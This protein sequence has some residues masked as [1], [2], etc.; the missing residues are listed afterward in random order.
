MSASCSGRPESSASAAASRNA[1]PALLS[2]ATE[3]IW[4]G[5]GGMRFLSESRPPVRPA[6]AM[7]TSPRT[8]PSWKPLRAFCAWR[9][10]RST[11][12][13][14]RLLF[15]GLGQILLRERKAGA[16]ELEDGLAELDARSPCLVDARAGE[17]VGGTGALADARESV[18][19]EE[20]LAVLAGFFERFCAPGAQY[21]ALEMTP[22]RGMLD[23][24]LQI[25]IGRCARDRPARRERRC[26]RRRD[27]PDARR[28]SRRSQAREIRRCARPCRARAWCL[29]AAR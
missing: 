5:A 29:Q 18:A 26:R 1:R 19:G 13:A 22:E 21:A 9:A 3:R 23:V 6:S 11:E 10:P 2:A 17:H 14:R 12:L 25:A 20:W 8:K 7:P 28:E 15:I 4:L 24:V 16:E 27:D